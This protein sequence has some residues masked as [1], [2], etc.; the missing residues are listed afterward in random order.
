[1]QKKKHFEIQKPNIMNRVG[2]R[3]RIT[4]KCSKEIFNIRKISDHSQTIKFLHRGV[5]SLVLFNLIKL[6][7]RRSIIGTP[8]VH[9]YQLQK[10]LLLQK[11]I[12]LNADF[13]YISWNISILLLCTPTHSALSLSF[14]RNSRQI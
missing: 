10:L 13:V 8:D 2:Q 4:F 7:E 5:V 3:K 12:K 1:M 11:R 6:S 14:F 9:R